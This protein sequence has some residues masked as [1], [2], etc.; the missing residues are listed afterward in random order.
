MC[1]S[2]VSSFLRHGIPL[3]L[4]EHLPRCDSCSAR[5]GFAESLLVCPST[6]LIVSNGISASSIQFPS[7]RLKLCIPLRLLGI[8]SIPAA[9]AFLRTIEWPLQLLSGLYGGL[10]LRNIHCD[11]DWGRPC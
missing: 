7:P 3:R 9:M 10:T 6:S 8:H 2:F 11:S 1:I 4:R 5:Y